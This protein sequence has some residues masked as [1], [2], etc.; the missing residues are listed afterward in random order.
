VFMPLP[1]FPPYAAQ[2]EEVATNNYRGFTLS[3]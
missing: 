1:G 3:G 2:C